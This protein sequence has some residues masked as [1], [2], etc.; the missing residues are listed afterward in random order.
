M[1]LFSLTPGMTAKAG[2]EFHQSDFMN[3]ISVEDVV[4]HGF[5]LEECEPPVMDDAGHYQSGFIFVTSGSSPEVISC[6]SLNYFLNSEN[7][8][9]YVTQKCTDDSDP[10]NPVYNFYVHVISDKSPSRQSFVGSASYAGTK[11]YNL[12]NAFKDVEAKKNGTLK[13]DFSSDSGTKDN[14]TFSSPGV[15]MTKD[16]HN[17]V[18]TNL[19]IFHDGDDESIQNYIDTGNTDGAVNNKDISTGNETYDSTIEP[20]RGLRTSGSFPGISYNLLNNTVYYSGS[21]IAYTWNYPN[22]VSDYKYDIQIRYKVRK[23][24]S[25][26]YEYTDWYD[27]VKSFSYSTQYDLNTGEAVAMEGLTNTETITKADFQLLCSKLLVDSGI[28]VTFN[29]RYIIDG[30]EFRVRHRKGDSFSS[31]VDIKSSSTGNY[32]YLTDPDGEWIG[33]EEYTGSNSD[34]EF[35]ITSNGSFDTTGFISY[36]KNGFGLLGNNGLISLMSGLF[37]YIPASVWD[38]IKAGISAMIIVLLIG[39]TITILTQIVSGIGGSI[40]PK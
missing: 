36:I 22:N 30:I 7:G 9:I 13:S 25:G 10:L 20:P 37:S 24:L 8:C 23:E 16:S 1:L 11:E 28:K 38:L 27:Y 21:G 18:T 4:S 40:I 12:E 26:G 31:W 2:E 19:P 29:G 32:S 35:D 3:R 39:A 15:K 6:D 14:Y 5:T 34:N 33:D 17:S